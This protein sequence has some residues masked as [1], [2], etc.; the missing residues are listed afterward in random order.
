MDGF[1]TS[2]SPYSFI[3]LLVIINIPLL[4]VWL[5]ERPVMLTASVLQNL[6]STQLWGA[7]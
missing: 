1:V 3:L 7:A 5:L 2:V 4:R 6:F